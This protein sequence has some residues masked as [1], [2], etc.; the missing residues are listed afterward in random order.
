[1]YL[2]NTTEWLHP[3]H[4]AAMR[5][6]VTILALLAVTQLVVWLLPS[7]PEFHGIPHY[8]PLHFFM[9]TVSIVVSMM[10]F[11]VGWNSRSSNLSGNAVL[12][13]SMFFVVGVF[14]FM[15]TVSYGGMP[16]FISANDAQKHLNFW[17]AARLLASVALL[18]VAARPLRPLRS[19]GVR[20]AIFAAL[21]LFATLLS[22]M[23]IYHQ[24]WLPDWFISGSGLTEFKKNFEYFIIALNVVTAIMLWRK[25]RTPQAINVVL[26][27]GAVC[28]MAMSEFFFTLYTTLT[29]SYSVLGHIYKVIAYLF[30]Y[31]AIVVETIE[32]PFNNLALTQQNLATALRASNTGLWDWNLHTNVVSFSPEWKAMLGYQPDDLPDHISTWESLLHPDD[33]EPTVLRVQSFLRSSQQFYEN[34]FRM[35]HRDGTY[36]WI[37]ARG[38]KK[39]DINGKPF[40]LTGSHVEIS[41][42][43]K[44][45]QTQAKLNRALRLLSDCNNT[46]VHA[47]KETALLLDICR[48]TVEKGGYS[49]AWVGFAE[50][51]VQKTVR[52]AAQFGDDRNCLGDIQLSWADTDVGRGPVGASIR[53]GKT[54]VNQDVEHDASMAPWREPA[55]AHGYHS[56]ISL[57]LRGNKQILG[58]LAIYGAEVDAFTHE[59]ILLLEELAT[60]LVYGI[61]TLR[62]RVEHDEA[63]RQLDFLAHHDILTGLPNRLS[64]RNTF[65]QAVAH[66]DH[67]KAGVAVLFV[68][69]DNFKQVNDSLGHDFGDKLLVQVAKRLQ[70]CLRDSDTISRQGGDEFVILLPRQ[71]DV[72][73]IRDATLH[74]V[75]AFSEPFVIEDYSIN[76]TLS[77]GVVVYPDDGKEFDT[78]LKNADTALYQAKDSGR[79]TFSLFAEEMGVDAQEQLRLQGQLHNAIKMQEF[80]LYY[81]PQIDILTGNI[82]GAEALLRWQHPEIGLIPPGK[83][84]PLAERTGL[85]VPIGEWVLNEACQQA[86][87]WHESGHDLV[88]AVNLSALQ[89]R[90]GNLLDT[91]SQALKISG[92]PAPM[93]E[94]ELTE[95]IL[96][97]DVDMALKTLRNLKDMGVKL[98]IDDFGTGYSS[99]SYL[100]RLAVNK[101]K[102]D[103]SFVN[104]ML[105]EGGA[106]AIVKAIIQLGHALQL[107]VI[108]EGVETQEQFAAL[109]DYGCDEVQGYLFNRPVPEAEFFSLFEKT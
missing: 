56:S 85:I 6:T 25:M 20:Y 92:L 55:L 70:A 51:D 61:E 50:N 80:V 45:E 60:D 54:N 65:E 36:L 105:G 1:M 40:R 10:V 18:L 104:D 109:R 76:A 35:R 74:I 34:E 29:G 81:Q 8:L 21:L 82:V 73:I 90:R 52:V 72:N 94:L 15:H 49:M 19:R 93:L 97:H 68:D 83:F 47:T 69:L 67:E 53:T 2:L 103:Q 24:S 99:L 37:M 39:N 14:D 71:R 26:I 66:A 77:V 16:D 12:L 3:S 11:A 13:A 23:V 108:A 58:A 88:M 4:R 86:Q 17:L 62:A 48:L 9:E 64:L 101:L 32:E 79:N 44:S 42:R 63:E 100:Q 27:F 78:L 30:I 5:H 107:T 106:I 57:P 102:I 46:L 7:F 28:T 22:W 91:V 38:E 59:E 41:E 96:L 87:R 95:S 33:R 75:E 89:F 98:S 43:K 31:R 84:I